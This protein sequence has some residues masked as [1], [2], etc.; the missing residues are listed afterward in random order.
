MTDYTENEAF[1]AFESKNKSVH[2]SLSRSIARLECWDK[3]AKVAAQMEVGQYIS[4]SNVKCRLDNHGVYELKMQEPKLRVLSE[5]DA[6][7]D[8]ILAALLE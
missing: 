1:G 3:S 2:T 7:Y 4:L 6:K 5:I 8:K